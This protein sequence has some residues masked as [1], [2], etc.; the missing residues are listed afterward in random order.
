V[1]DEN[2]YA[3]EVT[4]DRITPLTATETC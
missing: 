3:L 2:A 1:D 4:G